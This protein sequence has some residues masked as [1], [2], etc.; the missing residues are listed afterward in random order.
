MLIYNAILHPVDAPVI[1]RGWLQFEN[2]HITALGPMTDCPELAGGL[3]AKGG[4]LL[5]G[6]VDA[7]CHLGLAGDGVGLESEDLNESAD[8]CT[9]QLRAIDGVN[10]LDRTFEEARKGGITT[11]VTGPGS[12]NPIAGQLAAIKTQGRIIDEMILA[13]PAAMK[14]A[15]GENPKM[16]YGD[17]EES[18]MTRMATAALMREKLALALEY[19]RKKADPEEDD[20][21]FDAGLEALVPVV[22]GELPVHFHAHRA[23][24]IATAL[25][26]AREFRLRAVV[27]HG[28]EGY[29]IGDILA[30]EKV[31]VVVGPVMND[32][33]KPELAGMTGE[34]AAL[35]A[36]EGVEVAICTDHPET[37]I[38]YLP[39][40]AALA[41][42][43][44]M[45]PEA[46]LAAITLTAAKIA[47]VDHRVGSLTVG[48]DADLVLMD[49]HPFD[50]MTR[51]QK[52]W[53]DGREV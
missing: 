33:G 26:I 23:D 49:G 53:I 17:R 3:D 10:P 12:A 29:R 40:S 46:A 50:L 25:R 51:V 38:Q 7:H 37:P 22:R 6:F 8:P 2:G 19:A 20:P 14:F 39:L 41:A 42:K 1:D 44:G 24:D 13:A 45:E 5:P 32:R 9:P 47:G 34:N 18:P 28:T 27:V 16:T 21:D 4:H 43:N 30:K 15:L 31:P 35:L 48:K 36:R 52:V 11:V